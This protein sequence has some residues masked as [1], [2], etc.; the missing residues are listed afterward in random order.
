[1]TE[2]LLTYI[3]PVFLVVFVVLVFVFLARGRKQDDQNV[4]GVTAYNSLKRMVGLAVEAGTRLHVSVGR[5]SILGLQ[6]AAAL[7]ALSILERIT[8]AASISDCPPISTSGDGFMSILV[9]STLR[10]THE[11]AGFGDVQFDP[12]SGQISGLTPLSYVAGAMSVLADDEKISASLLVGH[13]DAEVALLADA[14]ERGGSIN[15]AGSD[16]LTAQAVLYAAAHEPL[17]GEELYVGGA[18]LG[19]GGA[20]MASLR[21]QDVMRWLLIA[22]IL[23]SVLVKFFI[24]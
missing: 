2:S 18:Y 3:G 6:A 4:R 23:V 10:A 16:R 17:I 14:G 5:G 1:M 7:A 9:Q 24:S 15:I 22:I 8:R 11:E 13:F 19:T 20:H 12:A 21:A